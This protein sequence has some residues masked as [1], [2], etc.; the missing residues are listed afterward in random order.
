MPLKRQRVFQNQRTEIADFNGGQDLG[1]NNLALALRHFV[2]GGT[3]MV[4]GGKVA[5]AG[6]L[7]CTVSA[8][9][10]MVAAD[11][12]VVIESDLTVQF[13]P[14]NSGQ[15]RI[16]L[17]SIGYA[18]LASDQQLRPFLNTAT[19]QQTQNSVN[20]TVTSQTIVQVTPGVPAASPVAPSAPAGHFGLATVR[21][22]NGLTTIT[23][24]KITTVEASRL[25]ALRYVAA[26]PI[27]GPDYPLVN[28]PFTSGKTLTF[29][30]PAGRMAILMGY[31][32][33]KPRISATPAVNGAVVAVNA[34]GVIVDAAA[35]SVR[36]AQDQRPVVAAATSGQF[37]VN[38]VTAYPVGVIV[39]P[40]A[41]A[42]Y[43]LRVLPGTTDAGH[44]T[45]S[46]FYIWDWWL[47][48][49]LL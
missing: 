28:S 4:R 33:V 19:G 46:E 14:N 42:T 7:F 27:T 47:A 6:G 20:T 25:D 49:V 40:V 15:P 48:G 16:D 17:V 12:P 2:A 43:Q 41:S 39:G 38:N 1:F 22:D 30:V 36:L 11:K 32:N 21:I 23:A 18:E 10:G 3:G 8:G 9:A 31:A 13:T 37:Y 5:P 45:W 44:E 29:A 34:V 35:P 26:D 24:D